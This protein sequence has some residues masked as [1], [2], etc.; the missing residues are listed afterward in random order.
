MAWRMAIERRDGPTVLALTRQDLAVYPP[1]PTPTGGRRSSKGAYM[2][3]DC[4]GA[5]GRRDRGHG[6]GGLGGPRGRRGSAGPKVRVVSMISPRAVHG[7][8]RGLPRG[9]GSA[10]GEEGRLR[11]GSVLRMEGA[12]RR[13]D[14]RGR[15]R[16][17][18]RVG[19][20]PEGRRAPRHHGRGARRRGSGTGSRAA[21][22]LRADAPGSKR[23]PPAAATVACLRSV[24]A[25]FRARLRR[26]ALR[27]PRIRRGRA[28]LAPTRSA[29]PL[30]PRPR[31]AELP[32]RIATRASARVPTGR[33]GTRRSRGPR[34]QAI[35]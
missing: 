12:V 17:V 5:P 21:A 11:G 3:K 23:G 33:P 22:R 30:P 9:A 2:A 7:A 31:V 24:R 25:A 6:L 14:A 26:T 10:H 8:A 20:L 4:E 15:D 34:A 28:S 19:T 16:P 29:G 32:Q 1:R 18:R 35:P 13:F 27:V